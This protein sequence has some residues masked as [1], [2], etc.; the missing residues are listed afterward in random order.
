MRP[1]NTMTTQ[2]LASLWLKAVYNATIQWCQLAWQIYMKQVWLKI[3]RVLSNV[4]VFATQDSWSASW[5]AGMN[6]TI[7]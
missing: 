1:Y 2:I 6:T 4:N 7:I 3:V 5:L